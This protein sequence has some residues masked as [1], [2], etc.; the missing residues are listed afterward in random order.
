MTVDTNIIIG[1]L[2]GDTLIVDA[3][4]HWREKGVPLFLPAIVES[5]TLAFSKLTSDE[6]KLIEKFLEE[7]FIFVSFDRSVARIT[8]RLRSE[9]KLKFPDAAIA[10]TALFTHT[11]LVTRNLKDFRRV[12]ELQILAV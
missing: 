11:P 6:R 9:A 5:E 8:A 2:G 12:T 3:I 7:N 4:K 1:Y 10:A